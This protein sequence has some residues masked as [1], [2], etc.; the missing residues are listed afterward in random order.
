MLRGGICQ[1]IGYWK[2]PT[3]RG[4]I[5][6]ALAFDDKR[7]TKNLE[8]DGTKMVTYADDADCA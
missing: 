4:F 7:H 8:L 2:H 6:I 5:A 3:K 1:K